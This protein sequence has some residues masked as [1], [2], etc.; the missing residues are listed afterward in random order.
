MVYKSFLLLLGCFLATQTKEIKATLF[1][2]SRFIAI[3]IYIV[4]LIVIIGLPMAIFFLL[5]RY[6]LLSFFAITLTITGLSFTISCMLFIPKLV[7]LHKTRKD[8]L[9]NVM[10]TAQNIKACKP[11][12]RKQSLASLVLLEYRQTQKQRALFA[13]GQQLTV[14]T[15]NTVSSYDRRT[16][17]RSS[18]GIL[19]A[20]EDYTLQ[21]KLTLT[22]YSV[23]T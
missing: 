11:V 8:D 16:S 5:G 19:P 23:T 6:I 22:M 9:F 21:A 14:T 1:N 7:L 15:S 13:V 4:F 18:F 3:A 10:S 12:D 17:A 20:A 2:D